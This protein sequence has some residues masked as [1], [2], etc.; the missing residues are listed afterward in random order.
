MCHLGILKCLGTY[1]ASHLI[2]PKFAMSPSIPDTSKVVLPHPFETFCPS[3][4]Y[5]ANIIRPAIHAACSQAELFQAMD[6]RHPVF[7]VPHPSLKETLQFLLD[8]DYNHLG[9][10]HH[11]P[12][13]ETLGDNSSDLHNLC[14]GLY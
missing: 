2:Y 3:T 10:K 12:Y 4:N 8:T 5:S 9:H 14:C 6:L 1:Q 13:F 7:S 11:L